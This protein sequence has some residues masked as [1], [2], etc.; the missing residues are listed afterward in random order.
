MKITQTDPLPSIYK[1]KNKEDFCNRLIQEV[2]TICKNNPLYSKPNKK[3]SDLSQYRSKL[4]S[5]N[6]KLNSLVEKSKDMKLDLTSKISMII[7]DNNQYRNK[8]LELL[9]R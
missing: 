7:E 3:I 9:Q 2:I 1:F 4:I 5:K 8:L 6:E